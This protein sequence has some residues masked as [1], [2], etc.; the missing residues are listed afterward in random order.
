[1]ASDWVSV[2]GLIWGSRRTFRSCPAINIS[3][4]KKTKGLSEFEVT[5]SYICKG[6]LSERA[7]GNNKVPNLV[8]Q[9]ELYG[10][11]K[12]VSF[13][14]RR[15]CQVRK[16][17]HKCLNHDSDVFVTKCQREAELT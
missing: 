2:E 17:I 6:I 11:K 9:E 5:I 10:V 12:V 7:D 1:M 14:L 13:A 4:H 8:V 3:G 15:R 16:K